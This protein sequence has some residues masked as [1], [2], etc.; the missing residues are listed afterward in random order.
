MTISIKKILEN[1][2]VEKCIP[3][4]VLFELTYRCNLSCR[5]CYIV[6]TK[7]RELTF[8]EIKGILDQLV[9]LGTLYLTFTGGEIFVRR[10]FFDIARYAREKG[11]FLFLLTNG[12]LISDKEIDKLIELKPLGVEISLLGARPE[13]HDFITRTLGSFERAVSTIEKLAE[14]GITVIIKTTLMKKNITEYQ[15]IKNL[16][17]KLG[18]HPNTGADIIPKIDGNNDPQKYQISWEDRINFLYPDEPMNCL[19]EHMN[20]HVGP[21]KAGKA[22][23][24]ISPYGDVQP[25]ILMPINLGNLKQKRFRDIWHAENSNLHAVRTIKASD[26][27]ECAQCQLARFCTRCPGTAY[28]ETGNLLAPSPIACEQAGWRA[29][30][31]EN[32]LISPACRESNHKGYITKKERR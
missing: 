1:K 8:K 12:T 24:S 16:A 5:H 17:R 21:C 27:K 29:Y 10:D 3:L 25:C 7:Q 23:A 13:T 20:E 4:F 18:V 11:F 28:I 31:H 9:E 15:E 2:C 14:K 32:L 26:L 22:V 30:C 19:M 6:N